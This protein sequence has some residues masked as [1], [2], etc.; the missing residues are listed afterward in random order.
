MSG[1]ERSGDQ[2][3][4]KRQKDENNG[5]V[6][7]ADQQRPKRIVRTPRDV[8]C[9]RGFHITNHHGNLQFHILVNKY[10]ERYQNSQRRKDKQRITRLVI[11][12]TKKTGARFLKRVEDTEGFRWVELHYKQTYEKVSHTLRLQRIN[13]SYHLDT[14]PIAGK[15]ES[16]RKQNQ[17]SR[18]SEQVRQFPQSLAA[19][20]RLHAQSPV[21]AQLPLAISGLLGSNTG[22][23]PP[24][25][26]L[27]SPHHPQLPHAV[28]GFTGLQQFP[29]A[30]PLFSPMVSGL[31]H[32]HSSQV[33]EPSAR[34]LHLHYQFL[35]ERLPGILSNLQTPR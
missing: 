29:V 34:D 24:T 5:A 28:G 12:E 8:L 9:G 14:L 10:R 19:V 26:R 11:N 2:L 3:H 23:H 7:Y 21:P 6:D 13:E 27:H 4:C 1:D 18:Q 31:E 25:Q 35:R 30:Q 32:V 17:G 16:E 20:S 22:S 33:L 15:D